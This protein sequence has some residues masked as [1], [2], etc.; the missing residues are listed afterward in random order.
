VLATVAL[1]GDDRALV[2]TSSSP[3]RGVCEVIA[4]SGKEMVATPST[5]DKLPPRRSENDR[6]RPAAFLDRDGVINLDRGYTYRVRDLAFTPTA[7]EGI[8]AFNEAGFRVFV[9]TNQ[10]GVARG[11]YTV[12]DVERFHEAMRQRLL[13]HGAYIDCF[14]YCPFHPEGSVAEYAI[15][16][17]DRKPRPGMLLRALRE[18]PTDIAASVMI[19]DKESDLHVAARA[20]VTGLLVEPNVCDLEAAVKKFLVRRCE[21]AFKPAR[22]AEG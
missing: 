13:A 21:P 15:D 17:E 1:G 11:Y 19:G 5:V 14:Y 9:I 22:S 7:I 16:H 12:E 3:L 4:R 2:Q 18:W 8:K 10:S 20:G 6:I